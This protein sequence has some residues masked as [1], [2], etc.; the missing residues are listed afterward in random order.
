MQGALVLRSAPTCKQLSQPKAPEFAGILPSRCTPRSIPQRTGRHRPVTGSAA[1]RAHSPSRRPT[2]GRLSVPVTAPAVS[3]H[4]DAVRR[5]KEAEDRR[6]ARQEYVQ[7]TSSGK[8]WWE[9]QNPTN[10][11]H[12]A[13]PEEFRDTVRLAKREGKLMVVNYF[14]PWCHAC[15]SLHP[16]LQ[17]LA[18]DYRNVTFVSVNA[19]TDS[20]KVMCEEIGVLKLPY[21]HFIK[22]DSGIVA[23]FTA[24]LT[25]QKLQQLRCQVALHSA[26]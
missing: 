1:Q 9:V 5:R 4:P 14:G 16:K 12:V 8:G 2:V 15:K 17:K 10:M 11:H 20:L 23:E 6:Q 19:G 13:S 25:A 22:G 18:H 7:A 21:F 3:S 24:N 26:D